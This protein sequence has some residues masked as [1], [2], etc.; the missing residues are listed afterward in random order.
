MNILKELDINS[1]ST[2]IIYYNNIRTTFLCTNPVFHS[3][4]KH[5][6]I[7]FHFVRD[8]VVKHQL[9]IS[10]MYMINQLT[11]SRSLLHVNYFYY[12]GPISI[13]LT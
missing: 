5:I 4:M 11:D 6:V 2:P 7:D 12:I 10:H 3:Y 13:Y 9:R 1:T 8:Y